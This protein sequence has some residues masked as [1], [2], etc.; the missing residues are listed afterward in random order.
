MISN[1]LPTLTGEAPSTLVREVATPRF[2]TYPPKMQD[3]SRRYG[4]VTE[5]ESASHW[6][7]DPRVGEDI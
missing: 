1:G 2:L 6:I 7:P 4:I 3:R 5:D